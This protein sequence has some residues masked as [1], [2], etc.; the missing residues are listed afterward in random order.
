MTKNFDLVLVY[1]DYSTFKRISAI[2][3]EYLDPIKSWLNATQILYSEGPISLNWPNVL[4]TIRDDFEGFV[5]DGG[6]AFLLDTHTDENNTA[7]RGSGSGESDSEYNASE[8]EE[9]GGEGSSESDFSG[10]DDEE[11]EAESSDVKPEEDSES[12]GLDWDEH[13]RRA[14]EQ[15][16]RDRDMALKKAREV[17]MTKGVSVSRPA[18][19]NSLMTSMA[20]KRVR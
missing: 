2:P 19:K 7:N 20:Q 12:E 9:D 13:E 17:K 10:E 15:E 1:K 4:Q 3:M 8:E 11:S 6:W 16:K 18:P 5:E 14:I